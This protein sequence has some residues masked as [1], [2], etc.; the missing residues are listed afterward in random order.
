MGTPLSVQVDPAGTSIGNAG[1]MF[2]YFLT[3][4]HLTTPNNNTLLNS[5]YGLFQNLIIKY[6]CNYYFN[7]RVVKEIE[8]FTVYVVLL[9][10]WFNFYF[11]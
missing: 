7:I 5:P 4:P 10:P 8:K 2:L 9:H 6:L 1:I 3:L 11:S